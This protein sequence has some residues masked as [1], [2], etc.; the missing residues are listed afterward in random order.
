MLKTSLT[1][2]LS[3][4]N[5]LKKPNC[6]R[7]FVNTIIKRKILLSTYRQKG[8]LE[9]LRLVMLGKINGKRGR[10]RKKIDWIQ[11]ILATGIYSTLQSSI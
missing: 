6:V 7:V 5:I 3:N 4:A 1:A 8:K 10:S 9:I 2:K 11:N